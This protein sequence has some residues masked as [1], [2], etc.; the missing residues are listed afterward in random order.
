MRSVVLRSLSDSDRSTATNDPRPSA[1]FSARYEAVAPRMTLVSRFTPHIS[2]FLGAGRTLLRLVTKAM[3]DRLLDDRKT[4]P[5]RKH[6][7][8][9]RNVHHRHHGDV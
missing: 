7:D 9:E 4:C 6:N 3:S 5:P 2:R 1:S 8:P